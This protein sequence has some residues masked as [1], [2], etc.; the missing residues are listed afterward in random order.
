MGKFYD[1][2]GEDY[3]TSPLEATDETS[4]LEV[5]TALEALPNTVIPQGSVFCSDYAGTFDDLLGS[6]A[7]SGEAGGY[8]MYSLTFTGNPGYLKPIEID[9]YLDGTRE[10][11]SSNGTAVWSDGMTGEFIDYFSTQCEKVYVTLK[12][13]GAADVTNIDDAYGVDS[14]P[15]YWNNL[16]VYAK[17]DPDS[18]T[19]TESKLLKKCLGDSDG[20]TSNNIEVYDWDYGADKFFYESSYDM[21]GTPHV[22][23]LVKRYPN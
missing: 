5:V 8:H 9:T 7:Y 12:M 22:V 11:A 20:F 19:A 23:K 15:G 13:V 21:G 2:F 1:V 17:I 14:T 3:K 10:T 6:Y 18:L 16:N 4:C